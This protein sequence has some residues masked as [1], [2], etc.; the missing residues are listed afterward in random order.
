MKK[1]FILMTI[2]A[3]LFVLSLTGCPGQRGI[4]I[5][6]SF[7][8]FASDRWPRVEKDLKTLAVRAGAQVESMVAN[9]DPKLQNEQI[10]SLARQGASAIIIV[11]ED[12]N[13]CVSA[14]ERVFEDGIPCIAYDRFI[15]S[16]KIAAYFSFDYREAGRLQA[17][18]LFKAAG[19]GRYALLSGSRTDNTAIL[20]RLGQMDILKSRIGKG[21]VKIV[22]DQWV[23]Q[24]D[25]K[26][27]ET[28]MVRILSER[29]NEVDAVV[30]SNDDTALGAIRVL[31][32]HELAGKTAV[33]GGNATG[34]G[35]NAL[36]KGDLTCTV[37]NDFREIDPLVIDAA[38]KLVKKQPLTGLEDFKLSALSLDN[39][40]KGEIPCLFLPVKLVDKRTMYDLVVRTG[41]QSYDD[42]YKD[43]PEAQKPPAP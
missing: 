39:K 27:A 38:M 31:A 20:M 19:K 7:S 32:A 10:V 18:A 42:V 15:K 34:P 8:D 1:P 25:A 41:F 4:K 11:A 13:S 16:P 2:S 40:L 35:C 29:K 12:G 9:H 37:L 6:L 23:D 5:G 22:A 36:A 14:V 21:D 17:G 33:S 43:I 24:W 28:I 26:R 30:A 3:V